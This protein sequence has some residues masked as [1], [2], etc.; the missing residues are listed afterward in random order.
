MTCALSRPLT[1]EEKSQRRAAELSENELKEILQFCL[2]ARCC[3]GAKS[4]SESPFVSTK[5][6]ELKVASTKDVIEDVV[7]KIA[8]TSTDAAYLAGQGEYWESKAVTV[9]ITAVSTC[10]RGSL[11]QRVCGACSAR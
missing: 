2:R 5:P 10:D 7:A 11:E 9:L 1:Y 6:W 8:S 3:N 4:S